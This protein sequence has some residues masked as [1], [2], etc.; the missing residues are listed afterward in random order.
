MRV[1]CHNRE[2]LDLCSS[3]SQHSECL[4]NL[5][6]WWTP[7]PSHTALHS[8]LNEVQVLWK[9]MMTSVRYM[10]GEW[11]WRRVPVPPPSRRSPLLLHSVQCA[12]AL[13]L[14]LWCG[15]GSTV[16]TDWSRAHSGQAIKLLTNW[17]RNGWPGSPSFCVFFFFLRHHTGRQINLTCK[18]GWPHTDALG[19]FNRLIWKSRSV[20]GLLCKEKW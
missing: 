10:L 12:V 1:W 13:C 11:K 8:S 3:A 17:I 6:S 18:N 5:L 2:N 19:D 9:S 14:H 15:R 7:Q 16:E 20:H 4:R